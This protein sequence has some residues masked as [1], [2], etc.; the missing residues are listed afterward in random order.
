MNRVRHPKAVALALWLAGA[1]LAATTALWQSQQNE[2]AATSQFEALAAGAAA[3]L[4]ARMRL[5]DYALHGARGAV[6]AAG[7]GEFDRRRFERYVRSRDLGRGF[8]GTHGI[9]VVRR[10][11]PSAEAA[12]VAERR[13]DGDTDFSVL[14]IDPNPGERWVMQYIEPAERNRGALGLDI[15]SEPLRRAAAEAAMRSGQTTLTA[16]ITLV[17]SSAAPRRAFLL[18]LPI[19]RTHEM[20]ASDADR[21]AATFGWVAAPLVVDDV[22]AGFDFQGGRFALA[23]R[24]P[25]AP[26]AGD[27]Y[28]SPG[29]ATA[30]AGDPVRRV[31]I[32]VYGRTWEAEVSALP[33]FGAQLAPRSPLAVFAAGLGLASLLAGLMLLA[34]QSGQ[35]GRQVRAE[36]ARRAAILDASSDAIVAESLDGTITDWNRGAE[37]MF[38][39]SACE[40][41]GRTLADLLI[42]DALRAEDAQIRRAIA[43]GEAVRPFDSVRRTRTGAFLD[44]SIAASPVLDA[45][46]TLVGYAKTLRDIT[47]TKR[48]E[49]RVLELNATLERQVGERTAMLDAAR[50]DL[51]NI[52]DAMPSVIGYWDAA[53][54]N[55]FANRAYDAW[56]G[57]AP[58]AVQGLHLRELLGADYE[59]RRP[60]IEA[61]LRGEPQRFE[62]TIAAPAGG[63]IHT[64]T[65]YLPDVQVGAVRGFYAVMHDTSHA[66]AIE[67]RLRASE[68]FLDQTGAIAGVGG[69]EVDLRSHVVTWSAQTHRIHEVAPDFQPS[70]ATAIEF[71][72]PEARPVIE[73]AVAE[74][75]AGGTG[76]DL[77]LPLITATGRR[78]WVRAVGTV[79]REDGQAVR[80]VGAFQD[81]TERK[82]ADAALRE[83]SSLLQSVLDAASEVSIIATD[84][85]LTIRVF[86][87][88]AQRLLGYSADEVVGRATPLLIHDADELAHRE[89]ELSAQLGRPV[90]GG[91]VFT[92]PVSMGE[93]HGWT[94]LRKDGARVAVSLVVTAMH[95]ET[96]AL[97]GYLGVAHDVTRQKRYEESLRVAMHQARQASRAKSQFLANMSHEIRTPMNAVIGLTYLL[98]Q[99]ALG[100]EQVAT[101]GKIKQAGKSLLALINDV[102]DLSKIEAGEL[103]LEHAPFGLRGLVAELGDLMTVQADAKH[104]AL[105]IDIP[106]D[107]PDALVGDSL[108]LTQVLANL[109]ANA[110]K[111][112]DRGR[113]A[114]RL[115][116]LP[117]PADA[118]TL[119]FAVHDTGI[120][121]APDAQA[122]LFAP[123]SQADAS[124]TRRFGGTG[125][126]LS[127][128][129]RLVDLMGGTVAVQSTPGVG[130]EFS[131]AIRFSLASA[132]EAVSVERPAPESAP[133]SVRGVRVLVVDDSDINLEVARRILQLGG[134]E[135]AMAG[136]GEE[137]YQRLRAEPEAFDVV[138][139]DVQMP[140]LDGNTATRAIRRELGLTGLPI[141]ALTA[142]A[143]SS[144]RQRSLAAGMDDFITK[145]FDPQ[146]LVRVI[147]RHVH[148]APGRAAPAAH[149]AAGSAAVAAAEPWP[150]IEGI[151]AADARERLGGD[152]ALF[153]SMLRRLLDEFG[154]TVVPAGAV[155]LGAWAAR[156]H[157]LR[158][159]AGTLGARSIHHL[160]GNAEAAC[161]AGAAAH[162]AGL[163]ARLATQMQRLRHRAAPILEAARRRASALDTGA[164][165]ALDPQA[166]H[167]LIG[168][169]TQQNM[170]ALARFQALSPHLRARLG[171]AGFERLRDQIDGL[172]FGEAARELALGAPR[173]ST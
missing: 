94:Y 22:L 83:T 90:A 28:T 133:A 51:Q 79:E 140:V 43:G 121:I 71:Y 160:A 15:A 109:V 100:A 123:F 155:D 97:V 156:L 120:G 125:L 107:L 127:I 1:A 129:K 92:E 88:G 58:D 46:G 53:Q 157:K 130:S 45:Q 4:G 77:E 20:P 72:A 159:S 80:L 37:R 143:L 135:V 99:T 23:L 39:H 17:Q 136:N 82:Q 164:D 103:A 68:A 42:P 35:R 19:Y 162:A 81:I 11:L 33:P 44:V 55:R 153:Q 150:E 41:I 115:Q 73:Q 102:L 114:L 167:E 78:L 149:G 9:G 166:L 158:G 57:R 36:Q 172:Q 137:A 128:V 138:L 24:D 63:V 104:I 64:L 18:L 14:Q 52:L 30:R 10:V 65:H 50:R 122:R 142:G 168:L 8:P 139:M 124:T 106:T 38:G 84:P 76:W 96:G 40:A 93:P 105:D 154:D 27:F 147:A 112:T 69:W 132:D 152:L 146:E 59:A 144:E 95:T 32:A 141:I 62:S 101:L 134:A 170:A 91:M 3:E 66:K 131:V 113:V 108:R 54:R 6:V 74:G 5:V 161:R 111:F 169:L 25:A 117:G 67:Q 85:D 87:A 34:A 21:V 173:A 126:G 116:R 56:F 171:A 165:G 26:A 148:A 60:H 49:R 119:R 118:L 145:P 31:P 7:P 89:Q 12:F 61:A 98:E 75:I 2:R 29:A 151:D 110:I 70:I 47:D 16:P 13:G 163:A 86:N 48:A